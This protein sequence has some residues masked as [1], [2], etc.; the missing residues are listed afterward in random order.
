MLHLFNIVLKSALLDLAVFTQLL[1][2]KSLF[3]LFVHSFTECCW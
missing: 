1:Y 2:C 3:Y